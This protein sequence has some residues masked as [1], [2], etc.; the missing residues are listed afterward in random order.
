MKLDF[1]RNIFGQI[2]TFEFFIPKH[3]ICTYLRLSDKNSCVL[4]HKKSYGEVWKLAFTVCKVLSVNF[5]RICFIKLTPDVLWAALPHLFTREQPTNV[6]FRYLGLKIYDATN[7][8]VRFLLKKCPCF[9]NTLP[10]YSVGV[11]HS[12]LK[13]L[14]L[15]EDLRQR[16]TLGGPYR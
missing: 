5:G 13:G 9:C 14:N 6:R 7:S 4:W 15:T 8:M 12:C 16:G 1:G 11:A 3:Q 2:Y 10:N